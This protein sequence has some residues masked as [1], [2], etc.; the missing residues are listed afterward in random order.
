M[1]MVLASHST[2][3]HPGVS[4]PHRDRALGPRSADGVTSVA[5]R[6]LALARVSLRVAVVRVRRAQ[7]L[8]LY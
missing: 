4:D 8:I 3:A 5:V 2:H 1:Q 7:R 6:V